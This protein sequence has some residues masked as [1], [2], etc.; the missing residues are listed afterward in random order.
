M[1]YERRKRNLVNA[2]YAAA[3]IALVIFIFRY[4]IFWLMPFVFA[5][6]VA[7][8]TKPLTN[9]ISRTLLVS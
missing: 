4:A 1:D 9:R 3:I 7:F 8:V 6:G 5:F 2:A